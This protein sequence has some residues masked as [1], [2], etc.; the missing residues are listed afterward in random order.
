MARKSPDPVY[1]FPGHEDD[2]T[3]GGA[4]TADMFDALQAS[5][6][7]EPAPAPTDDTPTT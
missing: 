3:L 4:I 5:A 1:V 6:T 7:A 2:P